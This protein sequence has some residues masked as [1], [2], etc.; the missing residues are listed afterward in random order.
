MEKNLDDIES[1][2]IFVLKSITNMIDFSQIKSFSCL[3]F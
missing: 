3:A 2:F 1:V